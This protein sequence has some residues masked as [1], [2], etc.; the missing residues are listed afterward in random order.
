MRIPYQLL[1]EAALLGLMEAFVLREGTDYGAC[2]ATLQ[3]KI[4]HVY[5][6]LKSGQAVVVFSELHG[7]AN[8]VIAN[9][10]NIQ[11]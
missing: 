3:A 4:D 7:N 1:S 2:E 6:Q 8:I 5:Q 9:D 10:L 11:S